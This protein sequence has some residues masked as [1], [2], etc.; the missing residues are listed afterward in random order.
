MAR[1]ERA[2]SRGNKSYITS[3]V[4]TFDE[5]EAN[6]IKTNE[7]TFDKISG[8]TATLGGANNGNGLIEVKNS[9]GTTQVKINNTGI[10]LA[11]DTS[12]VG[13]NGVLSMLSVSNI[14]LTGYRMSY[15]SGVTLTEAAVE[16]EVYIPPNFTLVSAYLVV[17][18]LP[19]KA[20][21][22]SDGTFLPALASWDK[23][24]KAT[25]LNLYKWTTSKLYMNTGLLD[26]NETTSDF[27]TGT[28]VSTALNTYTAPN[29]AYVAVTSPNIVSS[30]A[31]GYN[32]FYIKSGISSATPIDISAADATSR[33]TAKTYLLQS[34]YIKATLFVYGY[35]K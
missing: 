25:A 18:C 13:G 16:L 30:L 23:R 33:A 19:T 32:A 12:I 34:A 17:E 1:V 10:T 14:G 26:Y 6:F 29:Y 4:V 27:T 35:V 24:G 3:K 22:E 21:E 28:V 9:S 31:A 5:V 11:D 7:M 20:D 8:G 2:T 15:I